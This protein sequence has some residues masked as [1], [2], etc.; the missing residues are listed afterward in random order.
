[1]HLRKQSRTAFGLILSLQLATSFGAIALL[2]RMGPAIAK[3]AEEN[4][5]SLTAVEKMMAALTAPPEEAETARRS[6]EEAYRRADRNVTENDERPLLLEIRDQT[7]GAFS[8]D[9][10]ARESLVVALEQL[11]EVNRQALHK[12]D[13][14]AR[15]LAQAGA[16]AA[17]ILALVSFLLVRVVAHRVD[18]EFV[19]PILDVADALRSALQGDGFRRCAG[20]NA[21]PEIQSIANGVNHLL[22]ERR[23]VKPKVPSAAL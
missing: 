17:V 4:V 19:M 16:W 12:A 3:V 1:M 11:A 15:R 9:R 21:S 14:E 7:D 18:A 22:D 10:E 13:Q 6:F 2:S 23:A 20:R 8:G 5:E